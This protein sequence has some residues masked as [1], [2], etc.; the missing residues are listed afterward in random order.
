M[1][2]RCFGGVR[3]SLALTVGILLASAA[4]AE[5]QSAAATGLG[6][7]TRESLEGKIQEIDAGMDLDADLKAK[8]LAKYRSAL[9]SLKEGEAA[10][11]AGGKYA[12]DVKTAPSRAAGF[13]QEKARLLQ[14][15]APVSARGRTLADLEGEK[16]TAEAK[17]AQLKQALKDI[18]SER[19]KRADRK[20]AIRQAQADA[21]AKRAELRRQAEA[22]AA[23]GEPA[24][25]T[26]ARSTEA[27]LKQS[28]FEKTQTA[29]GFELAKYDAEEAAGVLR[30]E[31][32][33]RTAELAREEAVVKRLTAAVNELRRTEAEKQVEQAKRQVSLAHPLLVG[34]AKNNKTDAEAISRLSSMIEEVERTT[35]GIQRLAEKQREKFSDIEEKVREVGLTG[36]IGLMLRE[37]RSG[38]PDMREMDD[39]IRERQH[40]ID[41]A[42]LDTW[43]YE[44][45]LKDLQDA[46]SY[47]R[48]A[49]SAAAEAALS[50]EQRFELEHMAADLLAKRRELL[51]ELGGTSR[52]YFEALVNLDTV[53]RRYV[54]SS[55]EYLRYINERILWTRSA[56]PLTAG[57]VA[58]DAESRGWL[59]SPSHWKGVLTAAGKDPFE[60]PFA[61]WPT[62]V[63]IAAM[64]YVRLRIRPRLR[65]LGGHAAK[66]GF[67]RYN[68]TAQAAVLTLMSAVTAPSIL[69]FLS[70]RLAE[71]ADPERFVPSVAAALEVCAAVL[72][73]VELLR[74][75]CRHM[76]LAE[77]HFSW[78]AGGI[79]HLRRALTWMKTLG[80]PVTFL[81][82]LAHYRSLLSGGLPIE[83]VLFILGM[84]LAALT[85]HRLL[86]RKSELSVAFRAEFPESLFSRYL[87][88]WYAVAVALPLTFAGLSAAG[89]HYSAT[90]VAYRLLWTLWLAAGAVLV[91]AMAVRWI[92]LSR[93]RLILDQAYQR[94]AAEEAQAAGKPPVEE[95]DVGK[96]TAQTRRLVD[97]VMLGFAATGLAMIWADTLPAIGWL[98]RPVWYAA[99]TEA[100]AEAGPSVS[101]IAGATASAGTGSAAAAK[102]VREAAERE[103]VT[104]LDLAVAV[105]IAIFTFYASKN[106]P[107]LIEMTV[108]NRI[109]VDHATRY[110]ATRLASYAIVVVG[111]LMSSGR[112]GLSWQNVQW[113]AAALTVGLGFGLQE[114]FANFVS[115]VIILFERPVRVGDVVTIDDVTGV[116]SRIRMRA[117]TITNWDRKEFIVPNK[118]FITGR[119]LNW[120]LSDGVNRVTV[121]VGI[122]LEA[123]T[124]RAREILL[125]VCREH[126]LVL[127]DP[128]PSANFEGFGE[129]TLKMA[130]RCFLPSLDMR[131]DV[132]HELHTRVAREFREAGIDIAF[133]QRDLH[134]RTV[135]GL[136][137]PVP[138]VAVPAASVPVLTTI[139]RAAG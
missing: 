58:G 3:G 92:V 4:A 43:H 30:L 62:M 45:S 11:A 52:K 36:P 128:P 124:D 107:G 112:L 69:L 16:A 7:I 126:P 60:H 101:P 108:L 84:A 29:L 73:P 12:E 99:A 90:Q 113:L 129:S 103:P 56:D 32:D 79:Q 67:L 82:V 63:A 118:E 106:L 97:I 54:E 119:V 51:T 100:A 120:T 105:A 114:V 33:L 116:V 53:D 44:R 123:D 138:A 57:L 48:D 134:I 38:F 46:K 111:L 109:P 80:L 72:F 104:T 14:A 88:V 68:P 117:T 76:G 70:W 10:L 87:P 127:A 91:R 42:R 136:T 121:N 130:A 78:P 77:A 65:A 64:L 18:E 93:R 22:P 55:R 96:T 27:A 75:A 41:G 122:A 131:S 37:Q 95:T 21:D 15:A 71:A 135:E 61:F 40:L 39:G 28:E 24:A 110:A 74:E 133:P 85:G 9:Q 31:E 5:A 13:Q 86:K 20:A 34:L 35:S 1:M 8:V 132:I 6:A 139:E 47:V 23:A 137:L 115:G 81:T 94:R 89:Y 125:R 26:A 98:D 17:V 25:L 2:A 49:S 59:L 19:K 50:D 102:T 66:R 83:R